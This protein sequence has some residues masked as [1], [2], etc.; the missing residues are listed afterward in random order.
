MKN[1]K[2][3]KNIWDAYDQGLL[4]PEDEAILELEIEINMASHS[5][6]TIS[7]IDDKESAI[8]SKL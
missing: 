8:A 7:V 3:I 5:P 1:T 6:R 4:T 2:S